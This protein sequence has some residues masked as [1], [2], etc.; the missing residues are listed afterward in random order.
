MPTPVVQTSKPTLADQSQLTDDAVRI[1]ALCKFT[2]NGTASSQ[3]D[4]GPW[5]ISGGLNIKQNRTYGK[6][7]VKKVR[8]S[9]M[10]HEPILDQTNTAHTE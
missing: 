10:E 8:Q 5:M 9:K 2:S 1:S 7:K 4:E 6:K 3:E